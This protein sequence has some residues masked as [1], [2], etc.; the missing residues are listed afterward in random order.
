MRRKVV[1]LRRIMCRDAQPE[2]QEL[3]RLAA[4]GAS[5]LSAGSFGE[6]GDSPGFVVVNVEYCI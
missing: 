6:A 3:R 5:F 1:P 4:C 2:R